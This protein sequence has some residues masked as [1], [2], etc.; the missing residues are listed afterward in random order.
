M[1]KQTTFCRA[2]TKRQKIKQSKSLQQFDLIS[3]CFFFKRIYL[4]FLCLFDGTWYYRFNIKS[5]KSIIS[6]C[7]L[8][9]TLGKSNKFDLFKRVLNI[10]GHLLFFVSLFFFAFFVIIGIVYLIH[11]ICYRKTLLQQNQKCLVYVNY[12][13]YIENKIYCIFIFT[14]WNAKKAR[15]L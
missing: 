7:F 9:L 11:Y 14:F 8:L 1:G 2:Q 12:T 4:C 13:F 3:W 15:N 6:V 5:S 10:V